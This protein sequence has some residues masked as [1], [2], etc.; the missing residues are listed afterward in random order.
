M[1]IDREVYGLSAICLSESGHSVDCP[2]ARLS[3]EFGPG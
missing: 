1:T 2:I 3:L